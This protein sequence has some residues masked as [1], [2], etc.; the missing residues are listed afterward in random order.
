MDC[1]SLPLPSVGMDTSATVPSL[2]Y[3]TSVPCSTLRLPSA[4]AFR[5]AMAAAAGPRRTSSALTATSTVT[6]SAGKA[7]R[8]R[9]KVLTTARS[10]G[11]SSV[12]VTAMFMLRA[13]TDSASRKPPA[14]T[15]D[16][17]GRRMTRSTT[18]DQKR[19]WPAGRR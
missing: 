13:G 6:A 3:S 17:H 8:I 4:R 2:L 11:R 9:S 10:C 19:D 1:S 18:V 15:I 14:I 16:T 12:V 5:S 7:S